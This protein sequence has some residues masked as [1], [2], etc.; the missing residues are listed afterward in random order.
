MV[1]WLWPAVS[2]WLWPR[3][4]LATIAIPALLPFLVGLNPRRKGISKRSY[5]RAVL[6]D[7]ALGASQFGLTLTFLAY[8]TWLM[9]DA[10]LRTLARLFVTHR[11]LLEWV[12]AAQSKFL[13]DSKLSAIYR[14]MAGGVFFVVVAVVALA[15][16]RH[17]RWVVAWPFIL[18]LPCAPPA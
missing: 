16:G 17:P 15:F 18:L 11:N 3:F 14:R 1:G 8:Q 7:L 6:S 10:I 4:M 13:A 2:P 12:T 9:S 5:L